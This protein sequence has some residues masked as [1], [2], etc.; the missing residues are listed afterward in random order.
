MRTEAEIKAALLHVLAGDVAP[1]LDDC[2]MVIRTLAWVLDIEVK[3]CTKP[4][5]RRGKKPVAID[6]FAV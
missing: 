3:H 4:R 5:P 6:H 2:I 1:P